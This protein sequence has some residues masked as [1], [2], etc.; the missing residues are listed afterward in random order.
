MKLALLGPGAFGR[1]ILEALAPMPEV[2]LA[3]VVARTEVS[4]RRALSLWHEVRESRG[5][6]PGSPRLLGRGEDLLGLKE[7]EGVI[8]AL[9]PH[10]QA[11]WARA[12]LAQGVPVFLEKPG[13]LEADD[14][15]R[16]QEL[17]EAQAVPA[18][19]DL[20]MRATRL[21]RVVRSWMEK[22][23]L[24]KLQRYHLE[25]WASRLPEDHWFWDESRSGGL[26]KEH[27]VHFVD[28]VLYLTGG[29]Y[30]EGEAFSWPHPSLPTYDRALLRLDLLQKG[31]EPCPCTFFH[32]FTRPPGDEMQ[33]RLLAFSKGWLRIEGWIPSRLEGEVAAEGE[34]L[35]KPLRE[36]SLS[37]EAE[38]SDRG[39]WRLKVTVPDPQEEYRWAIA[40]GVKAWMAGKPLATLADGGRALAWALGKGRGS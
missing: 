8:I 24:G 28:E 11:A 27:G 1:F 25:N 3:A 23:L 26:L 9:P 20:V 40:L 34:D 33:V 17:A 13:A 16:L 14:L 19:L 36:S 39:R 2:E 10:L 29:A 22:D 30:T 35:L 32:S 38:P 15:F 6:P 4:R 7:L 18:A 12:F 37:W 5:L 21:L 31:G